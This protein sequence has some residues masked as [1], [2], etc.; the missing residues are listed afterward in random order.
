M[1]KDQNK[2]QQT[3]GLDPQDLFI[4]ELIQ[5]INRKL[6]LPFLNEAQEEALIRFVLSL[7][8]SLLETFRS[9]KPVN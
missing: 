2:D 4:S 3:L 1:E 9:A 7:L 6:N 5:Q 8:F